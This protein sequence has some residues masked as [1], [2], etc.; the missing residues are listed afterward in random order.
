MPGWSR[1]LRT[2]ARGHRQD[3]TR[4]GYGRPAYAIGHS[5]TKNSRAV[6]HHEWIA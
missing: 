5:S 6:E 3:L 4:D 1:G 2:A